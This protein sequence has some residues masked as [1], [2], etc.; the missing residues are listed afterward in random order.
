M[1]RKSVSALNAELSKHQKKMNA[2]RQ[3]L[4]EAKKI[5]FTSTGE[6][7]CNIF[8]ELLELDGECAGWFEAVA[9]LIEGHK[10]EFDS[11]CGKKTS[12]PIE[13]VAAAPTSD[14]VYGREG[15]ELPPSAQRPASSVEATEFNG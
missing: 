10:A 11:L 6:V 14:V 3:E 1:A 4:K 5:T 15:H 7:A 13:Q 2:L 9:K 12:A 8:P